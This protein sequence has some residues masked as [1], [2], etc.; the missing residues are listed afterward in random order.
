MIDII[1]NFKFE[2]DTFY[3]ELVRLEELGL[4]EGWN[5]E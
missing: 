4:P 1:K 2:N 5:C 3:W